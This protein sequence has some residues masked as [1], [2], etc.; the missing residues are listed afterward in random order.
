V[1]IYQ[2]LLGKVIKI[3]PEGDAQI[4]FEGI[5]TLQWVMKSDFDKLEVHQRVWERFSQVALDLGALSR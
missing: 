4:K 2:G 5:D 3:D 1:P